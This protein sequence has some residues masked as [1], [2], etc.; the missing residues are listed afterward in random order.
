[1]AI[2]FHQMTNPTISQARAYF[3]ATKKFLLEKQAIQCKS[4]LKKIPLLFEQQKY[5]QNVKQA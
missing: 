2:F 1:M 4:C 3:K 5:I